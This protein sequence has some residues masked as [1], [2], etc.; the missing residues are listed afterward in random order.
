LGDEEWRGEIGRRA[1]AYSRKRIWREVGAAYVS[2]FDEVA[3]KAGSGRSLDVTPS[4][5][6][7]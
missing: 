2:L 6:R 5:A 7:A 4:A 1:Y 3:R